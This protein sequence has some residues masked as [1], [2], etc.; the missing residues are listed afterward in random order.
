[1]R[2]STVHLFIHT[3]TLLM[4]LLPR[5]REPVSQLEIIDEKNIDVIIIDYHLT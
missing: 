5:M 4:L 1:M 3:Y 2:K